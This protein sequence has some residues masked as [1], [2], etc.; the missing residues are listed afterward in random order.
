[1]RVIHFA[2]VLAG[3][4]VA[5][6]S[7]VGAFTSLVG[8]APLGLSA[9]GDGPS[10]CNCTSHDVELQMCHS[11]SVAVNVGTGGPIELSTGQSTSTCVTSPLAPGTCQWLQYR[12]DCK[13]PTWLGGYECSFIGS[14]IKERPATSDEC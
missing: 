9:I 10:F 11:S 8:P 5:P 3:L 2:F 6:V 1:M 13:K 12:F 4:V 14:A 7:S